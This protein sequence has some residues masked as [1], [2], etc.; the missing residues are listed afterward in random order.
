MPTTFN[1]ADRTNVTLSNGNLTGTGTATTGAVRAIDAVTTGK[2]YWE[3][4]YNAGSN[5]NTSV[6]IA[7]A[8][9]N[10]ASVASSPAN[11]AVVYRTAGAI[12]VNGSNVGTSIGAI[13]NGAVVCIAADIDNARIWFRIGAAGNWNNNVANNP[14]TNVG[15]VAFSSIHSAG[16]AVYPLATY[17]I[18]GEQT[19]ANFGAT[20]FTGTVPSGFTSGIGP[21]P[22]APPTGPAYALSASRAGIG[23][24][25]LWQTTTNTY[26][27][28]LSAIVAEAAASPAPPVGGAAQARV[29][30]LA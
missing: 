18:S 24:A 16:A 21:V 20:G 25:V 10:T 12:W 19:T 6:G 7:N 17:G 26:A 8:T 29:M 30:V 28:P 11:A 13:T 22:I 3:V 4:T 23:S 2:Y 5:G 14:A 9:A 15:G 1:P 27:L